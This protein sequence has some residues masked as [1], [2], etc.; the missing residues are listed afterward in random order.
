MLAE[1]DQTKVLNEFRNYFEQKYKESDS[2]AKQEKCSDCDY[3]TKS[4]THFKLHRIRAHTKVIKCDCCDEIILADLQIYHQNSK[5]S[6]M[7]AY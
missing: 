3:K 2:Y 1:E 6:C 4:K 7:E 5:L